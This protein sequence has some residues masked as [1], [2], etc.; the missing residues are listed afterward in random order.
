MTNSI[1]N[2]HNIGDLAKHIGGNV[3]GDATRP[4]TRCH[5]LV[6]AGSTDISF[7]S[8][9]KYVRHLAT[10]DAGG[11]VVNRE[12]QPASIDRAGK[13]PLTVIQTDDP[14]FSFRELVVL[15]HGFRQHPQVGISPQARVTASA[16]IGKNVNIHS[17]ASIGENVIIGDGCNIYDGVTIMAGV[18]IGNDCILYPSCTIYDQ[19]TLGERVIIHSGAVIGSDGYG[20]ASHGGVHHKIPQI[21]NVV[22][23]DDVEI[24]SNSVIE[25]AAMES[26]VIGRGTKLGNGVVIGHNCH[27]GEYNLLVSQVGIAGSTTTG[28]HVVMAGQAGVAGHLNIGNMVTAAAQAGIT[29]NIADKQTVLGS[30]A[31]EIRHA[32]RVYLQLSQLPAL[33]KRVRQLE[34]DIGKLKPS[35]PADTPQ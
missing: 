26:T 22:V 29:G 13:P 33:V 16:R 15:L 24:G 4:I 31:L 2:I 28:H 34:S 8:N 27:I 14:Y 11:V 3:L 32:R 25:R 35:Q 9:T 12:I 7:V 6:G 1:G 10:T 17:L 20:F 5:G 30:P 18:S 23:E 19:C 21:G